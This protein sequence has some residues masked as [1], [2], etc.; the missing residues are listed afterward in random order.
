MTQK[1]EIRDYPAKDATT[2]VG[3]VGK[4]P[5][6]IFVC[7]AHRDSLL[8]EHKKMGESGQIV[9]LPV[10]SPGAAEF[11]KACHG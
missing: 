1:C 10:G 2:M 4:T 8:E 3:F 7:D 5:T 6:A 9:I 11:V